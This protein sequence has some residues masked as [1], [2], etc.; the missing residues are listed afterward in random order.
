VALGEWIGYLITEFLVLTHETLGHYVNVT[1]VMGEGDIGVEALD[2]GSAVSIY[3]A[4]IIGSLAHL[5][6]LFMSSLSVSNL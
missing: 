1:N 3:W 6:A 4:D 2:P 5:S